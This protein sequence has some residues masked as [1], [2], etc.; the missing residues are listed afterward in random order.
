MDDFL[1]QLAC[2]PKHD[3]SIIIQLKL[4]ISTNSNI[5]VE[6]HY[7]KSKT[8]RFFVV[9]VNVAISFNGSDKFLEFLDTG[10]QMIIFG[11]TA[12]LDTGFAQW[13]LCIFL[14]HDFFYTGLTK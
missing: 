10:F 9:T 4:L 7:R 13:T 8:I 12:S 2:Y 1:Y 14:N 3:Q 6:I 5:I 11:N